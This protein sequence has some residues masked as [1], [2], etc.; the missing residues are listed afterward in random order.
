MECARCRQPVYKGFRIRRSQLS[1]RLP[2]ADNLALVHLQQKSG[3]I[4]Q[5]KFLLFLKCVRFN[6]CLL[7]F[8]ESPP[9]SDVSFITYQFIAMIDQTNWYDVRLKLNW[10][11]KS[12]KS[13]IKQR[14]DALEYNVCNE[15]RKKQTHFNNAKSFS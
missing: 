5:K 9:A 7:T 3:L 4:E 14:N 12:G 6:K 1:A 2:L 15:E 11:V 10:F 8:K 13:I